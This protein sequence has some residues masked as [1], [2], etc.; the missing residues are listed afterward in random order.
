[1]DDLSPAL[2]NGF[3]PC[4]CRGRIIWRE[5]AQPA[6]HQLPRQKA[7][8]LAK[9]GIVVHSRSCFLCAANKQY[10]LA[11]DPRKA[12]RHATEQKPADSSASVRPDHYQVGVPLRCCLFNHVVDVL[13]KR[14]HAFRF[15]IES[16]RNAAMPRSRRG[17]FCLL[18]PSLFGTQRYRAPQRQN[19]P[20]SGRQHGEAEFCES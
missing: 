1:M 12:L 19:R 8:F 11:G 9:K 14:H 15:A 2:R 7:R 5:H 20:W 17:P 3:R 6:R 16:L 13:G 10:R 4:R 18:L